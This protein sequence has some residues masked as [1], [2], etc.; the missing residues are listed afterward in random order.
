M[1]ATAVEPLGAFPARLTDCLIH[2]ADAAPE[3]VFLAGRDSS[4]QWR[5]ITYAQA[6]SIARHIGQ[7]LLDRQLSA[8]RPVAILSEND[9]DHALLAL[10]CMVVGVPWAP[11]SPAYSLVAQDFE[12]LKYVLDLLSPGLVFA[13]P[14]GAYLKAVQAVVP[15]DVEVVVSERFPSDRPLTLL[16]TLAGT[17]VTSQVDTA[18]DAV[19]PDSIAKFLFTSGSTKTPKAVINTHRM[20]CASMQML[21]QCWPFMAEEPP[22]VVDWLPWHHTFGGNQNVGLVLYNGGSLY[23]DEGKPTPK[24]IGNT[25]ANLREISP[26][27]HFNVPKGWNELARALEADTELRASYY[28]RLR[29]QFYAG[30]SL[31]QSVWDKLDRIAEAQIG[32]RVVMTTG[33]GMTETSPC[34]LWVLHD[35]ARAGELGVPS[36]GLEIKL[37]PSGDKLEIRYRG[38]NVTPGYW[39]SAEATREAF[40]SDGFL[41]S[42]DAVRWRDPSNPDAGFLFDGRFAEDFKLD[43]GTWVHVGLLRSRAVEVGAPYV[44]DV[45][46][47]GH[48]RQEVGLLIVPNFQECCALAKQASDSPLA[49]VCEAAAV[50]G[51][52]QQLVNKLHAEGTGCANRV[53]RALIMHEPLS[54]SRGEVTDKGTVNQRAVLEHRAALVDLLYSEGPSSGV[55]LPS[56][57][58]LPNGA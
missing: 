54:L 29:L 51:F 19:G 45:V 20:L 3:R 42:G 58:S 7:A 31:S 46:I 50:R 55:I 23:I 41:C 40:D 18:H 36:P 8:K 47:T 17:E 33:F 1:H 14:G 35:S 30:A 16:A 49:R 53:G 43:T 57:G 37:V 2:W 56:D 48:N 5:H 28:R 21:R 10:G 39:R 4:G 32:E 52:F 9:L 34:A 12:R 26:T 27:I 15:H 44:Q 6:L 22:V 24:L 13:S 38:P 25:L 11:V